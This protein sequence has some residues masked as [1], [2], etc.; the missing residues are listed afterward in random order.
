M[1]TWTTKKPTEEGWY[2]VYLNLIDIRYWTPGVK[3]PYEKWS[4]PI[5]EPTEPQDESKPIF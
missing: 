3:W 5:P 2:W 1:M 4:G